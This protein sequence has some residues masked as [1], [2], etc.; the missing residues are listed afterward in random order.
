MNLQ[1]DE[2]SKADEKIVVL[3]TTVASD[4]VPETAVSAEVV[5]SAEE[6]Q[7]AETYQKFVSLFAKSE[8]LDLA[9]THKSYANEHRIS[10]QH[11][12]KLEF[13]GDSVLNLVLSD[14]LMEAFP[15]ETE[16]GLSKRRASLVNESTLYRVASGLNL[17]LILKLG[18]GELKSG[19][20]QKPRL[21]ACAFEALIGGLYRDRGLQA[22]HDFL[23]LHFSPLLNEMRQSESEFERDFKTRLQERSHEIFGSTPKYVL[24]SETGPSH[25]R[26]FTVEIQIAVNHL[27]GKKYPNHVAKIV[28]NGESI[29][30][31]GV[32]R[33]KKAAE[34]DAAANLMREIELVDQELILETENQ[35]RNLS[36]QGSE[37]V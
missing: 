28:K 36:Q 7:V 10:G 37:N 32:G 3:E 16:G 31:Q 15:A 26:D 34:Q 21:I 35:E 14:V 17:N 24:V 13:L 18:R 4:V 9:L 5:L 23:I 1:I 27:H 8:W 11:N 22:C 29:V 2:Q 19:G 30:M 12:E 33:S 25:S 6:I 20:A